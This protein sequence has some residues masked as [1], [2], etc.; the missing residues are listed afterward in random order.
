MDTGRIPLS[1]FWAP[2][3]LLF[4][5]ALHASAERPQPVSEIKT[6][7]ENAVLSGSGVVAYPFPILFDPV[8][9]I[10]GGTL[11]VSGT[12]NI[13]VFQPPVNPYYSGSVNLKAVLR[14]GTLAGSISVSMRGFTPGT[15]T[16]NAITESS[17]ETIVLGT[18]PVTSGSLTVVVTGS[19]GPATT[20]IPLPWLSSGSAKFGRGGTPFPAGFNPFD[21]ASLAISD[22][23]SNVVATATLTPV[24]SGYLTELSPFE[25]ALKSSGATGYALVHSNTPFQII[26][27][28]VVSDPIIGSPISYGGGGV[29]T[30][31][32]AV[33]TATSQPGTGSETLAGNNTYTGST[34]DAGSTLTISGNLNGTTGVGIA[35]GGTLAASTYSGG[36]FTLGGAGTTTVLSGNPGGTLTVTGAG[37]IGGTIGITSEPAFPLPLPPIF[38]PSVGHIAIH[39]Q[40]LPPQIMVLLF[41]DGIQF[42]HAYTDSNGNLKAYATEGGTGK[43]PPTLNLF[44][45]Q[46]ITVEN[47]TGMVLLTATF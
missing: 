38:N 22:S 43:L 36:T 41:V 16:V 20:Y 9:P 32:T 8:F 46:T 42:G 17:S 33:Q 40:G 26:A 37:T 25:P 4:A 29:I 24:P 11:T 34:T 7:N 30:F 19:D 14:S 1:R 15:Y 31:S 27:Y 45:V 18:L 35:V 44:D 6:L 21:V 5:F 23:N 10:P 39:A 3:V 2:F 28:P 13:P 47:A 12:A